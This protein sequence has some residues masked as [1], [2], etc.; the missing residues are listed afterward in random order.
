[1]LKSM[2]GYGRCELQDG[3]KEINIEIKSINHRYSD[4]YIRV[5]YHYNFLEEKV[6][7]YLKSHI[8]RGKVDVYI[9]I[10]TYG[11]TDK[12]IY[13]DKELAKAY[14]STLQTISELFNVD[15]DITASKIA[16][17]NDVIKLKKGD[18]D[19]EKIWETVK[20]PLEVA[21][22]N[23]ILMREKEGMKL[24]ENLLKK[25]SIINKEIDNIE[26][27]SLLSVKEYETRIKD[28]ITELLGDIPIDENRILTEV[29]IFSDKISIDEEI[30][31][32]RS[33]LDEFI[34]ILDYD[35]P[36]GKKLDFIIQEMNREINT[37]GSKSNNLYIS[38]SV[39]NI[40]SEIENMRE[41]IQN[42]E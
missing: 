13:F 40:K 27:K 33:H 7:E 22:A 18:E 42:I 4:F 35:Y 19:Q 14:I 23:L 24:K 16:E 25:C 34:K 30:V 10:E 17:Y 1:M 31:R 20:K 15:N 9:N 41:Q 28:K 2:T 36:V 6:R 5:P 38:K 21:V 26:E 37:I 12:V 11:D 39:V 8:S 32:L 3:Q 29:A